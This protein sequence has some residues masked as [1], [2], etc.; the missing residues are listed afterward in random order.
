MK[1]R[2]NNIIALAALLII[3]IALPLVVNDPYYLHLIIMV[4]MNGVL[5]MTFVLMLRAGLMS[6]SIAAFWA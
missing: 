1:T 4:G 2:P 6:L 3:L 5:A